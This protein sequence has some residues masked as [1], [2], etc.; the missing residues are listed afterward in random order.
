MQSTTTISQITQLVYKEDKPKTY[1]KILKFIQKKGNIQYGQDFLIRWCITNNHLKT[2]KLLLR[3]GASPQI[4]FNKACRENNMNII[5]LLLE[6]GAIPYENDMLVAVSN[7]NLSLFKLLLKHNGD[8]NAGEGKCLEIAAIN[9]MNNFVDF[10]LEYKTF[11]FEKLF[12]IDELCERGYIDIIKKILLAAKKR[13][14]KIKFEI[15]KYIER[16]EK[17]NTDT[18]FVEFL[19][20]YYDKI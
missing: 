10:I 15:D 7:A 5:N 17:Y 4:S 14:I 11:K 18:S 16:F 8:I 20:N 13:E 9:A 1:S 12:F 19:K 2:A 3:N 6:H